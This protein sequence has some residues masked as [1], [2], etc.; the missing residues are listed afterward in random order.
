MA[1]PD[2][3]KLASFGTAVLSI[4]TTLGCVA[5]PWLAERYGRRTTLAGYYIGMLIMIAAAFGWAFYLPPGRALPMFISA[6]FF[7]C[8]FGG[9]FAI[10]SLWLPELF[11]TEVRANYIRL[12]HLRWTLHRRRR[13]FRFSRRSGV[14]GHARHPGR[15]HRGGIRGWAGRNSLR[16]RRSGRSVTGVDDQSGPPFGGNNG[17]PERCQE[18]RCWDNQAQVPSIP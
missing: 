1:A 17:L 3:A 7:L 14:D 8:L 10:F 2:G 16:T 4:G 11:D 9:N 18:R 15:D 13:Q 5:A 12:L 6:L